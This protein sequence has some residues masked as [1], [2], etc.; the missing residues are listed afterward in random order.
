MVQDI[1]FCKTPTAF[2]AAQEYTGGYDA[3]YAQ[4]LE[5]MRLWVDGQPMTSF[6]TNSALLQSYC[7]PMRAGIIHQHPLMES[8]ALMADLNTQY[9]LGARS[10]PCI[11]IGRPVLQ[12]LQ[13]DYQRTGYDV[14]YPYGI[15][16]INM[17]MFA[18]CVTTF[19]FDK[20]TN[21][22]VLQ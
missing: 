4:T 17:V 1:V 2:T 22:V 18:R 9:T 20:S 8:F 19:S 13:I 15:D 6:A 14:T 3:S 11:T 12:N 7:P 21:S 10:Y 5:R 16:A